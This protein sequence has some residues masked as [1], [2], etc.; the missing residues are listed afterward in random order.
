MVN[1]VYMSLAL[2]EARTAFLQ[3][4]VPVG[5]VIVKEG[6][7]LSRA[8]NMTEELNDPT[9]HA[10]VLALRW[11]GEAIGDWRLKECT[12]YVTLEPC[13]MCAGA[14]A[15]ARIDQLVIGAFDYKAGAAGSVYN[16]V[17]DIGLGHRVRVVYGILQQECER[18]LKEFFQNRRQRNE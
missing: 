18:L 7:V 3:G 12:M 14:I 10:E 2:E 11:A 17:Q 9:A 5:A 1:E 16:V 8:H 15:A 4:E 13:V 6:S